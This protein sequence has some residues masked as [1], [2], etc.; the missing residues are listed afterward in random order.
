MNGGTAIACLGLYT[1]DKLS[2]WLAREGLWENRER[3]DWS[4]LIR[5]LVKYRPVVRISLP[6]SSFVTLRQSL[7]LLASVYSVGARTVSAFCSLCSLNCQS[8]QREGG[9]TGAK[10]RET[11]CR[12]ACSGLTLALSGTRAREIG[13]RNNFTMGAD[14]SKHVDRML[15][16]CVILR[17][18]IH[19]SFA[20]CDNSC[21]GGLE[22][23]QLLGALQLVFQKLGQELDPKCERMCLRPPTQEDVDAIVRRDNSF[24]T[25]RSLTEEQFA[26]FVREVLKRIAIERGKR[27]GLFVVG[28]IAVVQVAKGVLKR[29]PIF[30]PPVGLF[31]SILCPTSIVGPALG[32]AGAVYFS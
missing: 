8:W 26:H 28:G 12:Q 30:G 19:R 13:R 17:K 1:A 15:E 7:P 29:V 21:S 5:N 14:V 20:D 3:S 27:V 31:V 23:Y 22:D 11:E 16:E 6:P 10:K 18:T 32:V 24:A 2:C 25:K 9:K 4:P